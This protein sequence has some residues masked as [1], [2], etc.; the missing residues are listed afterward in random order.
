M[1]KHKLLKRI[2]FA[3]EVAVLVA[4]IGGLYV[5][6]QLRDR[7]TVINEAPEVTLNDEGKVSKGVVVTNK[8]APKMTGYRT[9]ALFGIDHRDKN[10]ALAGENSDTMIICSINNDTQEVRLVSVYRDTLLNIGD[11]IYAKANAAYAYGGPQQAVNMLN[12][13]LD[14]NITDYIT[15][16]FNALAEAVDA[17]GGLDIP[18]SYAEIVHMNNY[19]I[20]TAEETG[21]SYTPVELPAVK[22]ED[23][24]KI[25]DSYHLN[26]VQVTSYCRI[27]YTSKMDMGRTERQR[28]TI[29]LLIQKGISSGLTTIFEVMDK[30]FPMVKTSLSATEIM[31]LIPHVMGYNINQ[32]GGFPMNYK[33]SNVRGSII[34]PMT[35]SDNV[36]ALHY[37]LYG[38]PAYMPSPEVEAYSSKILDIVGGAENTQDESPVVTYEPGDA[39]DIF[40]WQDDGSGGNTYVDYGYTLETETAAPETTTVEPVLEPGTD[41]PGTVPGQTDTV[42]SPETT[43]PADPAVVPGDGT[44]QY[45]SGAAGGDTAAPAEPAAD[46]GS[47]DVYVDSGDSGNTGYD[48]GSEPVYDGGGDSGGYDTG[49]DYG[50]GESYSDGGGYDAGSYDTG[51]YDTGAYDTG[52][53]DVGGELSS[54]EW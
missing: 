13:N 8:E 35:L 42:V 7:L 45:D 48:A 6:G 34:V 10:E 46:Q 26:G 17:V 22:P 33:F 32:T 36:T 19:C 44:G 23:E 41:A 38:D 24:E 18:L 49:Y 14:L 20:E 25:L 30:V 47:T 50:G 40:I 15:V 9:Y 43:V 31:S 4:L 53:Y 29:Q 27:R 5:Y 37:F 54:G 12:T 1:K 21:K 39:E 52:A 16:D 11:D 2:L 51:S 28:W 3:F